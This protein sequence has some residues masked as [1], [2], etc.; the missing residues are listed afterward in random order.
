M[1]FISQLG[2]RN[3]TKKFDS[4]RKVDA[5][6]LTAIEEAMRMAPTSFGLQPFYVRAVKDSGL[7]EK[8][9][10]AGWNQPQFTTG[11]VVYVL[12][13]RD[14]VLERIEAMM[15]ARSGGDAQARAQ[16]KD[17]ENMM[18]GAFEGKPAAERLT[19]AQKQ[20][21]I[22]LGFGLAAAAERGV[23]S[24]PMEGFSADD[25]DKILGL[26]AGHRSTVVLAV[27]HAD[28]GTPSY[29]KWRF[30]KEDIVRGD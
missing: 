2:W 5:A 15:Q 7:R 20:C 27:G 16:L 19:W 1:T 21:Y 17:Y 3:A 6:D 14:D 29:P 24:C 18:K 12:V 25:F 8:L 13:A 10:A 23:S 22:A 9:Q 26:P 30:P 4:T 28:T 11:T